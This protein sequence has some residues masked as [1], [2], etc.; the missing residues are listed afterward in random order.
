MARTESPQLSLKFVGP[1]VMRWEEVP[2]ALR[3][4][5]RDLLAV[6]LWQAAGRARPAED[7]HDE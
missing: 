5:V 1:G 3:E 7:G 6:L 2:S 4:R